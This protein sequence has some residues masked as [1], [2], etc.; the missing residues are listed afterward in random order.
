[1]ME[2]Q[3]FAQQGIFKY[4]ILKKSII[5]Q[6]FCGFMDFLKKKPVKAGKHTV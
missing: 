3:T 2:Q 6:R 1:M 5:N 4:W